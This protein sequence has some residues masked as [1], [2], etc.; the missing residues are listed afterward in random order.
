MKF[1]IFLVLPAFLSTA[2]FAALNFSSAV[3][4]AVKQQM[5]K[6]I[7]LTKTIEGDSTSKLYLNIFAT[8]KLQGEALNQFFEKR[9]AN[10]DLN[11]CGG[12]AGV[13]ACVQTFISPNT[14]FLTQNFVTADLPQI[15]RVSILFHESRHTEVMNG[16]WSHVNCPTPY[17]DEQNRDIVG[18]ISGIKMEGKPAC[19]NVALGA[20]GLQAVM[21]KNI[22]NTCTTCSEKI[23]MDS[24]IFGDDALMRISDTGVR[25]LMRSDLEKK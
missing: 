17:L 23:L 1:I 20:Y 14:M 13:A 8:P 22:Q 19:D 24:E 6:D 3:P 15:Y 25:K 21:L 4:A 9:I 2:A 7:E 11:D 16:G 12:G 18:K 5:L 10:V